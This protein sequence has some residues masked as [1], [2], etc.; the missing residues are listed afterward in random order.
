MKNDGLEKK[1]IEQVKRYFLSKEE[2]LLAFLFGSST[3]GRKTLDS[4]IDIA[5]YFKPVKSKVE[6][7]EK[8]EYPKENQIWSD[9]VDILETDNIDLVVLNRVVPVL[10]KEILE[11][12]FNLVIK[13][14][15]L[16]WKFYEIVS[17]EAEDFYQF[18]EDY[19]RIYQRAKSI[20]PQQRVRLLERLQFL[21]IELQD[22]AI[23]QNL[24]LDTY[25]NDKV[26]RRNI[27]RWVENIA[28]AT[29]DIAKIVLASEKRKMPKSYK[30]A[31]VDFGL[32]FGLNENEAKKISEIAQLRNIL[33][34]EYL[35]ILYEKI[36]DFLINISPF[37]ERLIKSL[38]DY[39]S[40][41]EARPS[42]EKNTNNVT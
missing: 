36:K 34:H 3:K 13:N 41:S 32:F 11:N 35:D 24:T 1:N 20:P 12:G 42:F 9:L 30:E 16:Y 25:R 28:N 6:W 19:W 26:Q 10:A 37:Y 15:N 14:E 27:E 21:D 17:K 33:A 40:C 2:V 7:E 29:I 8:R 18:I 39:L 31:L 4:D 38:N 5:V 23:F 22:L